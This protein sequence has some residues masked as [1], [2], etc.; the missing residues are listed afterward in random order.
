[1]S[2][3]ISALA[4]F[5]FSLGSAAHAQS[6]ATAPQP[7]AT[8]TSKIAKLAKINVIATDPKAFA[9]KCVRLKGFWRDIGF[10]ATAGEA[11]QPDALSV[12]DLRPGAAGRG[13]LG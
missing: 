9:G 12:N 8:C 4:A 2:C 11:G 1:M 3:R 10:Y 7:A 13:S 5:T 6:A